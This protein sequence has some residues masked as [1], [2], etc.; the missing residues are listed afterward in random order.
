MKTSTLRIAILVCT[1]ASLAVL[2][3]KPTTRTSAGLNIRTGRQVF[4]FPDGAFNPVV[5]DNHAIYMSGYSVLYQLR[6][7]R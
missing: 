7:K 4:A 1:L 2:A 3:W 5:A 6:P